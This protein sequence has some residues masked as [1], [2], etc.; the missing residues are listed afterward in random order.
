MKRLI[1]V[2]IGLFFLCHFVD[3]L[4][5]QTKITRF[6]IAQTLSQTP[7]FYEGYFYGF[8]KNQGLSKMN[9]NG[10]FVWQKGAED[11]QSGQLFFKFDRIF[12]LQET[13]ELQVYHAK[14]GFKVWSAHNK[15][16]KAF[17]I[18]YPYIYFITHDNSVGCLGF[19]TGAVVWTKTGMQLKQFWTKRNQERLFGVSKRHRMVHIKKFSGETDYV[20]TKYPI[21][22]ILEIGRAHV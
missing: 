3:N 2:S 4:Q 12:V 5:A 7:Q 8:I 15:N 6:D 9:L 17:N 18:S 22:N 20:K 14:F 1:L 16:I 10:Q 19:D 13:G 11:I 21:R